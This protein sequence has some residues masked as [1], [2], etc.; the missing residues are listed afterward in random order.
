MEHD[1]HVMSPEEKVRVLGD[2]LVELVMISQELAQALATLVGYVEKLEGI[3]EF[4][5]WRPSIIHADQ[6]LQ[7]ILSHYLGGGGPGQYETLSF[8]LPE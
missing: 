7:D 1:F 3:P 2:D 8:E 6:R 5:P 4:G